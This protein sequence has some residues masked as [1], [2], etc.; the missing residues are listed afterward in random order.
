MFGLYYYI[1]SWW[2]KEVHA[3]FTV[4]QSFEYDV[5]KATVLYAYELVPEAY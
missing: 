4:E 2:G 3:T 5:V 1:V